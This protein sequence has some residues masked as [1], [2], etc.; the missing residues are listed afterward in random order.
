VSVTLDGV[1]NDGSPGG[2]G[3]DVGTDV[4]N[5]T[6]GSGPDT[7]VGD[8]DHN[9][10]N[11]GAGRDSITGGPRSDTLLG[12]AGNDL[13]AAADGVADSVDGGA[14]T[15]GGSFDCGIDALTSIEH[16]C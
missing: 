6:G 5:V 2:E 8:A 10:L 12:G 1:A 11:G 3:D 13:F 7:L 15:D 14:G 9:V 4:E 16:G